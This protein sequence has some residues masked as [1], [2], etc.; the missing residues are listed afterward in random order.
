[1]KAFC[2]RIQIRSLSKTDVWVADQLSVKRSKI[3]NNAHRYF[4]SQQHAEHEKLIDC[5]LTG[6]CYEN[7]TLRQSFSCLQNNTSAYFTEHHLTTW[8]TNTRLVSRSLNYK[9]FPLGTK[10]IVSVQKSVVWN[11][12]VYMPGDITA[13]WN[14]IQVIKRKT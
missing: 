12:I 8:Q 10:C 9:L 7:T 13:E 6:Q 14:C 2:S 4:N 5:I 11:N 3:S 1:M